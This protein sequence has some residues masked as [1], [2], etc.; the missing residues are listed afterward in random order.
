MGV[1]VERCATL[2]KG[3]FLPTFG[4]DHTCS[5]ALDVGLMNVRVNE[6]VRVRVRVRIRVRVRERLLMLGL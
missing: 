4:F 6:R 3:A 5:T 1:T 2:R